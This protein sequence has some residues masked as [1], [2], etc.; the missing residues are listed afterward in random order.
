MIKVSVIIPVYRVEKYLKQCIESVIHQTYSNIE[1]ILVDDGSPDECPRICDRYAADNENVFVIHKKNGGLS[2]AR[3]QG[4]LKASGDYVMIVDGDDWIDEITVEECVKQLQHSR[5]IDCV[6]FSYTREY[7]GKSLVAHVMGNSVKLYGNEAEDKIYRR[8]FGLI[9]E[10]LKH[11]ERLENMGSCCMKLYK[12]EIIKKGRFFDTK[13][14]GSSEDVL[15]N[16]FALHKCNCIVYLDKPFYHYR[17]SGNT[18]TSS[19]RPNLIIQWNHLFDIM[20]AFINENDLDKR[21][22]DALNSRIALSIFGIGM[23][24]IGNNSMPR[25][26]IIKK[27]KKYIESTRFENAIHSVDISLMPPIWKALLLFSKYKMALC[28]YTELSAIRVVR[29][30]L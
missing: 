12:A 5:D 25:T 24:E 10:E 7:S 29:R 4:I 30:K 14:V 8:L 26:A 3:E 17:K 13:E 15:F 21:Y 20:E 16:M 19:Y 23:N 27:L 28:L 9:G 6:I 18:I 1:I 22:V 11:P 2:S